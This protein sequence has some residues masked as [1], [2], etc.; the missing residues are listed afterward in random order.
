MHKIAAIIANE[1]TN[2]QT[3]HLLDQ[4]SDVG[5]QRRRELDAVV[6]RRHEELGWREHGQLVRVAVRVDA[7][8]VV[9]VWALPFAIRLLFQQPR[10]SE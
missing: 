3:R 2:K 6:A 8:R 10:V 5:R 4:R 7:E 1:D 9:G